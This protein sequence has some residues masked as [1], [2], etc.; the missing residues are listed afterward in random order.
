MRYYRVDSVMRN[1]WAINAAM[2]VFDFFFEEFS[3]PRAALAGTTP[4]MLEKTV[5][6]TLEEIAAIEQADG[7]S[8]E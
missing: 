6:L 2:R 5:E 7:Y 1:L 3:A 4:E 8:G